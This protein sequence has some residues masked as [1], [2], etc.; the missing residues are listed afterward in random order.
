MTKKLEIIQLS[1]QFIKK[2]SFKDLSYDYLA[3]QLAI[4][5]TAIHYYFKNKKDLGLAICNYLE[6]GLQERFN[7][8]MEHSDETAWEFIH[9]RHQSLSQDDIC[10]IV[11]LQTDLNEYEEV[12]REILAR[13]MPI[14]S[15]EALAQIHLSSIKGAQIYNRT[16]N[17]PFSE[18]ILKKIKQE[19]GETENT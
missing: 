1:V 18:T 7:Y 17:V 19:I 5:K 10:P 12:Y 16:L 6:T 3:K 4:T 11:S 15:A 9:R 2:A 14:T 13:N 8:F